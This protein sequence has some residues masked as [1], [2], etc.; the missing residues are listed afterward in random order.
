MKNNLLPLAKEGWSYVAYSFI[1]FLVLGFLDLEFLQFFSFLAILLFL[2]IFRNPEREVPSF[3]KGGIV[4]PVDGVITSIQELH[5]SNFSYKI[6]IESSYFNVSILRTPIESNLKSIN[7][8]RGA[9]LS[10][11]S[12]L[13]DKLNENV[14]FVFEDSN[15]N[16][17]KVTHQNVLGFSDI[18]FDAFVSKRLV[19]GSRYGLMTKGITNVYFPKNTKLDVVV[20]M[21]LKACE[22]IMAYLY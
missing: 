1:A 6:S 18:K 14:E 3:E 12:K 11:L 20:G 2:Y 8:L 4:S 17:I 22:S 9:K 21:E 15:S 13:R 10:K 5:D 19:Q 7:V 16:K